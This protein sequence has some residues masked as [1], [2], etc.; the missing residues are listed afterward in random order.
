MRYTVCIYRLDP[1]VRRV[2][3][4]G[5]THGYSTLRCVKKGCY[6]VPGSLVRRLAIKNYSRRNITGDST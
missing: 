6:L 5:L 4:I 3:L 2:I 1:I